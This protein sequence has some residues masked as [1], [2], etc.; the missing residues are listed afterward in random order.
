MTRLAAVAAGV[1][2]LAACT[3]STSPA[4]SESPDGSPFSVPDEVAEIGCGEPVNLRGPDGQRVNLT[5][6]W[7]SRGAS[8]PEWNV[9]QIGSCLFAAVLFTGEPP[10]YYDVI[11]D[12]TIGTDF[13]ITARCIDFLQGGVGQPDM[14]REYFVIQFDEDQDPELV[15][16]LDPETPAT[17]EAPIA[18]WEPPT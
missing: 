15:R 18:P 4:T 12:G 2:L 9:R 8:Q 7:S 6:L 17:C 10:G 13:V 1:I 3:G 5:G 16:C 11:C 14:G